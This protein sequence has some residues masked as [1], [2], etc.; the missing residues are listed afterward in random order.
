MKGLIEINSEVLQG[1]CEDALYYIEHF[2]IE[3][4]KKIECK[5]S[6]LKLKKIEKITY[7]GLPFWYGYKNSLISHFNKL[8]QNAKHAKNKN[9]KI[10]ISELSYTNTVM[11]INGNKE[12]NPIY[13]TN[14]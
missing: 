11:L 9:I 1:V 6:I 4:Y 2:D 8:L 14:Y 7:C 5:F 10:Y 3:P 13:I 12:A